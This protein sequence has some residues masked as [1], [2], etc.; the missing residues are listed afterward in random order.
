MSI[1]PKVERC[2]SSTI[3]TILLEFMRSMSCALNPSSSALML[4][5]FWIDVTI[6]VFAGS[7]LL[8]F[9][10]RIA[11]FS[12]ACTSSFSSAKPLYSRKDCVPNSI[13]SIRKITLS[14]SLELAISCADLKLVI[15]FPEPV[16]CHT[17]PPSKLLLFQSVFETLSDIALAA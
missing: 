16:V 10:T 2:A 14:A 13:L 5:I 17:Y 8:S 3:K 11:V 15:V 1:S 6:S 4:L 9:V 7:A 12:V